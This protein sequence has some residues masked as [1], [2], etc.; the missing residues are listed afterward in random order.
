MPAVTDPGVLDQGR[1]FSEAI[2]QMKPMAQCGAPTASS[3]AQVIRDGTARRTGISQEI[4]ERYV[5]SPRRLETFVCG[6]N[7]IGKAADVVAASDYRALHSGA[8]PGIVN[9][10]KYVNPNFIEVHISPDP[11]DVSASLCS[12]S[13][14]DWYSNKID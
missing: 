11:Y 9:S 6:A 14:L 5:T 1:V 13:L 2:R 4:A 10:P 7:P 8:D 12:A 3:T